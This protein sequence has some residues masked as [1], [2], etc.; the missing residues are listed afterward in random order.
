MPHSSSRFTS[1]LVLLLTGLIGCT[2][3]A[4]VDEPLFV[5]HPPEKTGVTFV[6]HLPEES[7]FDIIDY[8]YYYNGGGVAAGDV[9]N[10][11]LLDLYF[12]SNLSTNQLYLNRGDFVLEDV[13]EGAGVGGTADWT[14]GVTMADVDGDG[15][16]DI[17]VSV[18]SAHLNRRGSN[19]LFINN[20]DG[21]FS[22]R[23][24]EFGL[25]HT[26]YSTQ[27]YFLD[28]DN[29]GDLDVYLLKHSTHTERSIGV[30]ELRH[31]RHPRSGDQLLRNDDG[32]FVDVSEP[33]GIYGSAVGYGLSASVS[34]LNMDGCIDIYV[35]NDFHE[36]D[37][38]YY[39]N[40]DGTFRESIVGS[41]AHTSRFSMGTDAA[42]FNN[43]GLFD[44]AVLDM[45]PED[46]RILKIS[47]GAES[48]DL[49]ELKRS[50]GY[51]HQFA[52]NTLQL[53]M[54]LDR[55]SDIGYLAGVFATD[56]SWAALFGDLDN[57]G[58]QDLYI[59]NG[60]YR[61]P[62]DLDYINYASNQ[63]LM[64]T[65]GQAEEEPDA[66]LIQR[67]P[68]VPLANYAFRN[69][70][71]LK[72][73]NAAK[74]WGL[75]DD[76]FSNGTAYADLDNDGDLDL[77]VNNVNETAWIYENRASAR[78]ESNHLIVRL[79]GDA[80]NT[81]GFGSKIVLTAGATRQYRE[82][83][84]TRGWISSVDPRAHFGLGAATRVDS[85]TVIWPDGR[86]QVLTNLEANQL[87][88]V[89]QSDAAGRFTYPAGK[90]AQPLFRDVTAKS[91]LSFVHKENTF[92]DYNR[93]ILMPHRVSMD[94]PALA[95]GDVNGDGLED[96]FA[97]GA[98]WQPSKLLIQTARGFAE[99]NQSLWQADSL[100]EDVDA[101]FFDADGDSDLDLY[102]VS[103]GNEFWGTASALRD[104]LYINDGS[105]R[106][107]RSSVALPELFDNGC[108]VAPADFDRDGDIDLFVGSR[109]VS[110][111]YGVPPQSHLLRNDGNGRFEEVTA[112]LAAGLA[113]VGMVTDV[114]WTDHDGNGLI[115]LVVTAEWQP[116]RVFAQEANGFAD[117][118]ETVGLGRSN[119]WWN[120]VKTADIDA[121]GDDDL[122][123]G[124][125][126]LNS[127]LK[128]S[129]ERPVRLHIKDFDG[130][131]SLDQILTRY[132]GDTE[133]PFASI[134]ELAQQMEFLRKRFT[135]FTEFGARRIDEFLS[136]EQLRD[137]SIL[138]VYEF[139]SSIAENVG[140]TF[141]IRALPTPA[142]FAPTYAFETAD[143]DGDGHL[144]IV[145]GGNFSGVKPS[146]GHYDASQ[147]LLLR[148][149]G[150]GGFE[151][152]WPV[153]SGLVID[154]EVR[155]MNWITLGSN[156]ALIVGRNKDRIMVLE[157]VNQ[158]QKPS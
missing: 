81:A 79:T 87:I 130:N 55:F 117:R 61:R 39:N 145:L 119:G 92:M 41:M 139:A 82:I 102:V 77:V 13:T 97:G 76:G 114:V 35:A 143:F 136:E 127:V 28:Y 132:K 98:K 60:I 31:E 121:D 138:E 37:Y 58:W 157:P 99:T 148:G 50:V 133:Y 135:T 5:R 83:A 73:E 12:T 40:C 63:A 105:G 154:G 47:A 29:D 110:R 3:P 93:E 2:E 80:A 103:G 74:R 109:V 100:H 30:S 9:N 7:G 14:T 44:L 16:L 101:A 17:Y 113:S 25:A 20:G 123:L 15:W 126:G 48:F 8:L 33:A 146:R 19:E 128:A 72:F 4:S 6:N 96:V 129:F 26:G 23:A 142:Q 124:N 120:T 45:L 144:D 118:T 1:V 43:D 108:C 18:L 106:F 22:E 57:D 70:G 27:A 68:Q 46:E 34:D 11:G 89:R 67:M 38:L 36:N 107:T 71:D 125:L 86:F 53:N 95:V 111:N 66:A 149:D 21:T 75:A 84:P 147:G 64:V 122:L 90:P 153:E 69:T 94:G 140:G 10:D 131:G 152:L 141:E 59:T 112:T 85:L 116:V 88:D 150:S 54:G 78:A 155:K 91:G 62:N 104:R 134:E 65:Q 137:A 56:W 151:P 24:A 32:R 42:D 49:Y 115:D 51:H 52:R 158:G 156:R